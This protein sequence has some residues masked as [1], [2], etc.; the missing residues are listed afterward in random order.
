MGQPGDSTSEASASGADV[1]E[2]LSA[3][4]GLEARVVVLEQQAANLGTR[5][6]RHAQ[7]TRRAFAVGSFLAAIAAGIGG[8][9]WLIAKAADSSDITLAKSLLTLGILGFA[10]A[11]LRT[12]DRLTLDETFI[13]RIEMERA[14]A[15]SRDNKDGGPSDVALG[16]VDKVAD[17]VV[18]LS[19]VVSKS[20][21]ASK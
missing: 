13:E 4:G 15:R 21:D 2:A 20:K 7:K 9:A 5:A 11:L 12:A 1:V 14:R 3:V 8:P 10:Y 6:V 16:L 19:D 18:K 17:V